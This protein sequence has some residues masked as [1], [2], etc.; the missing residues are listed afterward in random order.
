[1]AASL[2]AAACAGA[3]AGP[4]VVIYASIDQNV[5]QPVL[6]RFEE[7]SGVRVRA[8][9]DVEAA[10][11]TGLVNRLLAEAERPRADVWWSGEFAQTIELAGR[12]VLEP[13]D[14]PSAADLAPNLRAADHTWT[15]FGGRGRVFLVNTDRLPP[16]RYPRSI[17]DLLDPGVEP[18]TVAIAYPMFG[19]TA[20]HAAALY[21]ALGHE[22]ARAFFQ[23]LAERGVRV[24]DGNAVVRDLVV[25]GQLAFGLTDTDDACA[26]VER[27]APVTIVFPDQEP[28]GLGALVV[29]NT[30]AVV[31][32][33]PN[34]EQARRLA[35]YL[36]A[37]Q[38]TAELV[39]VGWFHVAAR[40]VEARSAC[41]DARGVTTMAL[42]LEAVAAGIEPVK[43]EMARVFVR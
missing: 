43:V 29:P 36:L 26:A 18:A 11:T 6:E 37:P 42:D 17:H 16:E 10:K 28:G 19:T 31:A 38:T 24:V 23:A 32:G 12:G 40:D 14:S 13:Y 27:G 7:T 30:V 39:E 5:A 21:A 35:D 20:T 4:E 8:V 25:D 3:P 2:L 22:A 41:V 15:A 34:P 33:G 9:Y 1:L